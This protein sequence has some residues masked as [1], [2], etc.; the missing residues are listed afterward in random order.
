[1][2][3]PEKYKIVE[4]CRIAQC[5][6]DCFCS[7]AQN[8]PWRCIFIGSQC[9]VNEVLGHIKTNRRYVMEQC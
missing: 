2:R 8:G 4:M 6:Y 1:M 3:K 9:F 7:T 5:E